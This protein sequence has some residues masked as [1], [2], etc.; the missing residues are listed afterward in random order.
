MNKLFIEFNNDKKLNTIIIPGY[1]Q[2][3]DSYLSII[4]TIGNYSNILFFNIFENGFNP[5]LGLND[6]SLLLQN[7]IKHLNN[8]ILLGH[9]FGGRIIFSYSTMFKH[10][11]KIILLDAAGIKYKSVKTKFKIFK[12]KIL[13]KLTGNKE[14]LFNKFSSKEYKDLNLEQRNRFNE[15]IKTDYTHILEYLENET[16]IIWGKNDTIT[17]LKIGRKIH[18]LIKQSGFVV[19]PNSAHYPHLENYIYF[20][21]VIENY[22]KYL[23]EV[24]L[25]I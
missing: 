14:K 24:I 7:R 21:Q 13:K 9:S 6:Y 10:S 23:K 12:Y 18:K 17:P 16:L 19:V 15:I 22:Y 3:V 1:L 8:V 5:N 4:K 20:K 11:Y 25:S 2:T